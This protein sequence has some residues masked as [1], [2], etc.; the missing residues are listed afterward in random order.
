MNKYYVILLYLF[1]FFTSWSQEKIT[2]EEVIDRFLE[3]IGG[4]ERIL[5][6]DTRVENSSIINYG[7][8]G[9]SVNSQ[10]KIIAQSV[11]YK[12]PD[13][14]LE[15]SFSTKVGFHTESI[16]YKSE[17]CPWYY[18]SA[19]QGIKFFDPAPIKFKKDY[20][21]T[22]FLEPF[23]LKPEKYASVEGGMYRVDFKDHRQD[24][25]IQSVFFDQETYLLVKRAYVTKSTMTPWT[26]YFEN[27]ETTDGFTEP[28]TINLYGGSDLYMSVEIEEISYNVNL[29][30]AIFEPPVA[31]IQ[32]ELIHLEALYYLPK[33][34]AEEN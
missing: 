5:L 20:P 19:M 31:C 30:P 11:Y 7:G 9:G 29:N 33:A 13:H 1:S 16:L 18:T 21:R 2:S 23:N 27:Y 32:G 10:N 28:R 17:A 14:F 15:H 26:F 12:S 22:Y 24:G 3:K 8:Q 25:G 4:K 6:L 34:I